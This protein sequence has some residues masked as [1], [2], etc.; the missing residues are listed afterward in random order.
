MPVTAK[1]SRKF[2]ER[3]GDDITS[4]LVDWFN[5]VDAEYQSQ[6]KQTNDL[7]WERFKSEMHAVKAELR[8]E[9]DSGLARLESNIRTDMAG[10]RAEFADMRSEL[11]KWMFI[12]WTG[13]IITLGG[14]ILALR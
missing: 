8:S 2:Y 6:L 11:M 1:L 4:E 10:L 3:L 9:I 12:Y 5:S 13:A 14:L 7:N